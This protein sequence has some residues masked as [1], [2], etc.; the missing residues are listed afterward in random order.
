MRA[1]NKRISSP[2]FK[3]R[4]RR[5]RFQINVEIDQA[6]RAVQELLARHG[7]V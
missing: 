1:S 6:H 4:V 3:K 5:G 7:L 2:P